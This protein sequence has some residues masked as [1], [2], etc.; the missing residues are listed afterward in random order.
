MLTVEVM[1]LGDKGADGRRNVVPTGETR[2]LPFDT[3]ISAVGARVDADFFA[4][5]AIRQDKRGYA[6]VTESC[7]TNLDGVYVAGDCRRGAATIVEAMADSKRIAKDILGKLGLSHDFVRVSKGANTEDI[8]SSR[9]VLAE[10]TSDSTDATR[11]LMCDVVCEVCCE[12]CPNRA[13]IG[14]IAAGRPQI[15]HIDGMCNECGNCGIFCPHTGLP[16]KDKFTLF[17][18]EEG[19]HDSINKGVLFKDDDI[20][21]VR[22][23]SGAEYSCWIDDKRL[24]EDF[25]DVIKTIREDYGYLIP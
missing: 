10:K 1:K 2:M 25:R 15:V 23:E 24:S 3:V 18:S 5:S 20:V 14:I 21:L 17:W 9:A 13:N 11:C 12:V 16:Y 19:F 6:A 8:R 4:R 7:E 22:D